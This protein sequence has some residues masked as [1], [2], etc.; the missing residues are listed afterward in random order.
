VS[1]LRAGINSL[2]HQLSWVPGNYNKPNWRYALKQDEVIQILC[3]LQEEV[4][5]ALNLDSA[6]DGE[7]IEFIVTAVRHELA[8]RKPESPYQP[9]PMISK[10]YTV[11]KPF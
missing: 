5:T 1:E 8:S 11:K 6:N 4:H 9:K 10:P 3:R 2:E 7:A